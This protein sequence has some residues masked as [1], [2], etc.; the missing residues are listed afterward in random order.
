MGDGGLLGGDDGQGGGVS[1]SQVPLTCKVINASIKGDSPNFQQ[2]AKLGPCKALTIRLPG[3]KKHVFWNITTGGLNFRL[4]LSQAVWPWASYLGFLN[5][6]FL[7]G[8][9]T[10]P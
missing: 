4:C 1:A 8:K 7:T 9:M 2:S 6:H 10:V 5:L 3:S